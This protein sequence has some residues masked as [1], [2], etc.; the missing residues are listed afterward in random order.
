MAMEVDKQKLLTEWMTDN[1][2]PQRRILQN[3]MDWN[4][5]LKDD[6]RNN[7]EENHSLNAYV[8]QMVE[9]L[10]NNIS[11][12]LTQNILSDFHDVRKRIQT[13]DPKNHIILTFQQ[14]INIFLF[15]DNQDND[16]ESFVMV[17]AFDIN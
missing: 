5:K 6:K 17:K 12:L 4:K 1:M 3:I 2:A 16:D 13:E 7:S 8:N 11:Y 15:I 9:A 10:V 14:F